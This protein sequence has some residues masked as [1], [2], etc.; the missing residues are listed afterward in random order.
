[1]I[2]ACLKWVDRRPQVDPLD[3]HVSIDAR[4]AG[5][6]AADA[7][8]LEWALRSG[9]A[10]GQPVLAVTAGPAAADDV[11]REALAAG[12]ARAIR[13]DVDIS[14]P[15]EVVAGVLAAELLAAGV[16]TVWC[17]DHSLDRG[18]GSVPAYLAAELGVAQ[19]LGLVAVEL[20][21]AH[22]TTALRRLDGGRRER[23]RV[24]GSGVLSVE[25]ATARL[26]RAP[27]PAAM[28]ARTAPIDVRAGPVSSP[29][30]DAVLRPFRPRPRVLS[31][32]SGDALERIAALTD[33]GA[34]KGH[35]EVVVLDAAAAAARILEA[36]GTWGYLTP[37]SEPAAPA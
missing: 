16:T 2:A 24:A 27:L 7:A 29:A 9:Q 22:D 30:P 12:A 26:R 5:M 31:A 11:L 13:V 3:A 35:S 36:L 6:S 15:S 20:G 37:A 25:G 23:L 28:A 18:S 8:A 10:W 32:P 19:A 14:A 1:V 34:T 17:G 4:T 33:T 21:N